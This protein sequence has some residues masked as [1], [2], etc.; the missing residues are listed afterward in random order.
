MNNV[1]E[2]VS[3]YLQ[4][5]IEQ[6]NTQLKCPKCHSLGPLYQGESRR[7]L[8]NISVTKFTCVTCGQI[9][10]AKFQSSKCIGIE[11]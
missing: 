4:N 3:S 2:L 9:F 5:N 10:Y 6:E 8:S 11:E 1:K 7:S